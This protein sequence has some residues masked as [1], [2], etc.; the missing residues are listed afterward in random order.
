[1]NNIFN[2]LTKFSSSYLQL[3]L[4]SLWRRLVFLKE[5]E[6][7]SNVDVMTGVILNLIFPFQLA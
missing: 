2:T 1:M 5:S 3:K 4:E 7:L 6:N